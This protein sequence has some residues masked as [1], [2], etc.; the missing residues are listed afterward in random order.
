[1]QRKMNNKRKP[2]KND[3]MRIHEIMGIN[4][5]LLMEQA[6]V[7]DLV[8]SLIN[9]GVKKESALVKAA[10][11][12]ANETLSAVERGKAFDEMFAAANVAAR[13]GDDAALNIIQNRIRQYMPAT[14]E[15]TVSNLVSRPASVD[16]FT[17]AVK[18]G[19]SDTQILDDLMAV[20]NP[21]TGDEILD[22][23]AKN[24]AKRRAKSELT[25]IR[26]SLADDAASVAAKQADDAAAAAEKQAD[27]VA[28]D[29]G[30]QADETTPNVSDDLNNEIP[31]NESLV[32]DDGQK[33]SSIYDK[34]T[35][36]ADYVKFSDNSVE[37]LAN[38]PWWDRFIDEVVAIFK[39]PKER[40]IKIQKI[41]KVLESETDNELKNQLKTKLQKELEWVYKKSSNNFVYMRDWLKDAARQSPDFK[42]VWKELIGTPS[43]KSGWNFYNTFGS[44]AQYNSRWSQVWAGLT[45]DLSSL[46]S[47]EIKL[48]RYLGRK[49]NIDV[50]N[51]PLPGSFGKWMTT[52]SRMGL[53]IVKESNEAYI[54]LLTTYGPQ[55][56]KVRYLRDIIL[57]YYKWNL[58]TSLLANIR[59]K[60]SDIVYHDRLKE[61][62]AT[63]NINSPECAKFQNN[64]WSKFWAQ[65]AIEYRTN[66]F[67]TVDF[68]ANWM[69]KFG[70]G[71]IDLPDLN[72]NNDWKG[73]LTEISKLDPGIIG[74]IIDGVYDMLTFGDD[75]S[76]LEKFMATLDKNIQNGASNAQTALERMQAFIDA[77]GNFKSIPSDLT[78]YG[79]HIKI[80]GGK[81]YYDMEPYNITL[82]DEKWVVYFPAEGEVGQQ[83]YIPEEWWD[84]ECVADPNKCE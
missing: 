70:E 83:N 77:N 68:F 65:Y 72:F 84:I 23:V 47:A 7:D 2:L 58:Y 40:L 44:L 57:Y 67:Q 56:A 17:T 50:S 60:L 54:K 78:Q 61:C 14:I 33:V 43:T 28:T 69:K 6:W 4:K 82:D 12:V 30:K 37:L 16:V 24:A 81:L 35:W 74:N 19:R 76:E 10:N 3:L 45:S 46:F 9:A 79:K 25:K 75:P 55:A 53:P 11:R 39:I 22:E 42:V 49:T 32:L 62:A 64:A 73:T 38:A 31:D 36:N 34:S 8:T 29:A 20:F 41:A 1:M 80:I 48:G 21:N 5:P 15:T 13:Q 63:K 18:N 26:K 27:D 66:P 59:N 71:S 51:A 52:G